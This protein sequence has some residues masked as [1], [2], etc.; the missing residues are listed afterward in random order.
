[1][2]KRFPLQYK[3]FM[4]LIMISFEQ[5]FLCSTKH[6]KNIIQPTETSFPLNEDTGNFGL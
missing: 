1:M 4:T 5:G 2:C 6:Q 3:E